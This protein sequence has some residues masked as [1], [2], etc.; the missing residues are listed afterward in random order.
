[1]WFQHL[2]HRLTSEAG[3]TQS[4]VDECI[5]YRG[6]VIYVLY[7]DDSILTGPNKSE[8]DE[9]IEAIKSAKL[10][11]TVDGEVTDFLGVNIDRRSEGTIKFSQ[12]R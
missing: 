7:T 12:P 11:I 5:F 10:K 4:T 6:S 1:M 8:I 3:F 2:S 9:A